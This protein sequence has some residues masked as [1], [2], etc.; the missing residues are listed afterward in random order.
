MDKIP[1]QQKGA[2]VP[3]VDQLLSNFFKLD[4]E[5]ASRTLAERYL[6]LSELKDYIE[7]LM[8]AAK[9]ALVAAN[10]YETFPDLDLRVSTEEGRS[11]SAI[12]TQELFNGLAMQNRS[13][14]FFKVCSVSQ[15]ALKDNLPDGEVLV[16]KFKKPGPAGAP[17]VMV[18]KMTKAD[19]AKL[20]GKS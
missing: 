7:S 5:P 9:P 19:W 16:A 6:N 2:L 20:Q 10:V 4:E 3:V 17:Y 12:D 13:A 14:D 18:S 11:S 8:D 15:K 1:I